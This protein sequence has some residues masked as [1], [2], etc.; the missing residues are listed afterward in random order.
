MARWMTPTAEQEAGLAEWI[1]ERPSTVQA[2]AKRLDFYELFRM[3]STGQRVVIHSISED[4]TVTV[5]VTAKFNRLMFDR[6]VFGVNPDDLEPCDLPAKDEPLGS[7]M[8]QDEVEENIDALRV[9]VRPDLSK[10]KA[11]GVAVRRNKKLTAKR[12]R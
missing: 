4:G 10:L 2:I 5:N 8:T 6:Q 12:R 9:L 7:M 3:K 1:S 11:A